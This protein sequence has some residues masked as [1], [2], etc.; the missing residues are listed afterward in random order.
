[1][2]QSITIP[3]ELGREIPYAVALCSECREVRI[4]VAPDELEPLCWG[5]A[6]RDEIVAETVSKNPE[7]ARPAI[8]EHQV[9]VEFARFDPRPFGMGFGELESSKIT[10]ALAEDLRGNPPVLGAL[11]ATVTI[12]TLVGLIVLAI[13]AVR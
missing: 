8:L 10:Q 9:P 5:C 3:A 2:N 12:C 7:R 13:A 11:L 6:T 4:K 1:M